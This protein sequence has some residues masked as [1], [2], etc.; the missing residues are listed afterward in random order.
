MGFLTGF[1]H[2]MTKG[3]NGYFKRVSGD[4]V[5]HQAI[6]FLFETPP[7]TI[8]YHREIGYNAHVL[9][10]QNLRSG[11]FS[12]AVRALKVAIAAIRPDMMVQNV[13]FTEEVRADGVGW[14]SFLVEWQ[15]RNGAT[16][17]TSVSLPK[18]LEA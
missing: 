7:G 1:A 4:A 5:Y 16:G 18:P 17:R 10:F 2:P 9:I 3:K 13:S 14:V 12:I 11:K 8:P 15:A 6:R